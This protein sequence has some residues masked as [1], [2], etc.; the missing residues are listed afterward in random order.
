MGRALRCSPNRSTTARDRSRGPLHTVKSPFP[1]C[2]KPV[3]K[4]YMDF[5]IS[6]ILN[7]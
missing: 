1:I 4:K 2:M 6:F 3:C 5:P 7:A